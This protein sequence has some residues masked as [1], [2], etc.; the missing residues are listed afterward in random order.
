VRVC[1]VGLPG[2]GKTTIGRHLSKRLNLPFRDSDHVL[3]GRIGCSIRTYFEQFGEAQFRDVEAQV[4]DELTHEDCVLSTGGGA[5]LRPANRAHMHAR[6]QVIYLKSTPESL[7]RRLR[8]DTQRPLLQVA[9]PMQ[10][11]TDL[12][13]TRDPLYQEAAH[14]VV[15]TGRPSVQTVVSTIISQLELAG[16]LP[17]A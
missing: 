3:E 5:V 13:A 12:F 17:S 11:L 16:V 14:F 15:D 8:H 4:I 10:R 1:L 6:C 2:S 9:D 7:F